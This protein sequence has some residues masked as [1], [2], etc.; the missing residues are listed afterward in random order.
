MKVLA[1][2]LLYYW[3]VYL[4][5][6]QLTVKL[7]LE[8]RWDVVIRFL[9]AFVFI[10][11]VFLL[12]ETV[13]S[14]TQTVGGYSKNQIYLMYATSMSA[15]S[16]ME[17]LFFDGF[18]VFMIRSIA[19]GEFDKVLTKPL[20]PLFMIAFSYPRLESFLYLV[21]MVLFMGYELFLLAE[22]WTWIGLLIY[23]GLYIVGI[24]IFFMTFAIYASLAFFITKGSQIIRT[25]QSVNDQCY[26]P[27]KIY[28]WGIRAIL[29]TVMPA[30]YLVF[31]PVQVLLNTPSY[32]LILL[33]GGFACVLTL[34]CKYMWSIG[35]RSYSS[36]S[37]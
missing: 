22:S 27:P 19:T 9:Y 17:A 28:P 18:K 33:S 6:W 25:L 37:S 13:F 16:L 36:A 14:K 26:Y 32:G 5:L 11:G 7:L 2:R 30:A 8:Y 3:R 4:Q 15:W 29:Y 23:G 24:Y 1:S 10:A 34:I 20:N 12:L 21:F 35:L 31:I